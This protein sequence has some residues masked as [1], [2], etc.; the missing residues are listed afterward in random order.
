MADKTSTAVVPVDISDLLPD[1]VQ[2]QTMEIEGGDVSFPRLKVSH[3]SQDF[4]PDIVP[5]FAIFSELNKEDD[6]KIVLFELPPKHDKPDFDKVPDAGILVYVLAMKKGLSANVDSEGNV[7]PRNTEGAIFRSWAFDDPSAPRGKGVDTT[8]NYVLYV[9]EVDSSDQPH[10]LL[11][12]RTSTQTAR[13][14][15]TYLR[16]AQDQGRPPYTVPFRIWSEKRSREFG[17]QT[18]RWAIFKARPVQP[19]REYVQAASAMTEVINSL[20]PAQREAKVFDAEAEAT[21]SEPAI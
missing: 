9:P 20:T 1:L 12:T 7:V 10:R 4:V 14:M 6:N 16:L 11:L 15:N 2:T 13:T 3:P 19:D 17:G 21:T 5:P 8:Y 18:Q